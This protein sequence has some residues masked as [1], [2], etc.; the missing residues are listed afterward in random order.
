MLKFSSKLKIGWKKKRHW[1]NFIT[2]CGMDIWIKSKW[3]QSTNYPWSFQELCP[4]GPLPGPCP[5]PIEG[6]TA[7]PKKF[8]DT[9]FKII[10]LRFLFNSLLKTKKW[11]HLIDKGHSCLFEKFN[12]KFRI[13]F[14]EMVSRSIW[15]FWKLAN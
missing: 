4:P 3:F 12:L 5:G 8:L 11:T 15:V 2:G 10:W 13:N 7:T 9:S 1:I 6:I 14:F